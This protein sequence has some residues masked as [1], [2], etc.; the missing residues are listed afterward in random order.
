MWEIVVPALRGQPGNTD[1]EAEY[2]ILVVIYEMSARRHFLRHERRKSECFIC[3]NV[4]NTTS[5]IEVRTIFF[6]TNI[7]SDLSYILCE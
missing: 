7:M 1:F 6:E 4:P 2:K 5:R 3:A